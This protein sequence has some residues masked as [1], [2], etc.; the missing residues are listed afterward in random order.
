[1]PRATYSTRNLVIFST[2]LQIVDVRLPNIEDTKRIR[3][4]TIQ[5]IQNI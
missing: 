5:V 1:M 4:I 2:T 3:V